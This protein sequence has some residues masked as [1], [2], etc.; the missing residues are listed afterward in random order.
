METM[1]R[2]TERRQEEREERMIYGRGT[3]GDH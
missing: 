3:K 2:I 1:E